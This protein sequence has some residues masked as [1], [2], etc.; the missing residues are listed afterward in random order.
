MTEGNS[1]HF[2][3]EERVSY[4]GE[5]SEWRDVADTAHVISTES[6]AVQLAAASLE[7]GRCK[8]NAGITRRPGFIP[9][10]DLIGYT[11]DLTEEER[12]KD[13]SIVYFAQFRRPDGDS[14]PGVPDDYFQVRVQRC[15]GEVVKVGDIMFLGELD[16]DDDEGDGLMAALYRILGEVLEEQG[17]QA[18]F[19]PALPPVKPAA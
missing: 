11:S 17:D 16:D 4:L 5:F 14:A 1:I 8:F 13:E 12:A 7:F 6:Q 10:N 19:I 2:H 9:D 3:A 18:G 15:D